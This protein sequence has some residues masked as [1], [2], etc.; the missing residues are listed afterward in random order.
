ML[1]CVTFK[2]ATLTDKSTEE[3]TGPK[4]VRCLLSIEALCKNVRF[5]YH[6]AVTWTEVRRKLLSEFQ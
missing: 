4:A 5:L 6:W 1:I 3:A 2:T